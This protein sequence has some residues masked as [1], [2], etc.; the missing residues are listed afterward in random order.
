MEARQARLNSRIVTTEETRG[1][2][3]MQ[4]AGP[5]WPRPAHR[6]SRKPGLRPAPLG[7]RQ[8]AC[9]HPTSRRMHT[10]C[11]TSVVHEGCLQKDA[12]RVGLDGERGP[13]RKPLV[14]RGSKSL[15]WGRSHPPESSKA[16]EVAPHS[17]GVDGPSPEDPPGWCPSPAVT[18]E[19]TRGKIRRPRTEAAPRTRM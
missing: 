8:P 16:F 6:R 1:R 3:P 11:R 4:P 12:Q 7:D 19:G 13:R 17:L 14:R 10:P 2:Q 9:E 18:S 5:G 15:L